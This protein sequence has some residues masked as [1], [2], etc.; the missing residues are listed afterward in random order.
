MAAKRQF[1][2]Q[3]TSELGRPFQQ[4]RSFGKLLMI[5]VVLS[6]ISAAGCLWWGWLEEN[7]AL[8]ALGL[9]AALSFL[10]AGVG[11]RMNFRRRDVYE[12]A[13]K[14]D[15][16]RRKISEGD[17]AAK[18]SLFVEEAESQNKW[19]AERSFVRFIN[20]Y[21]M[22][23]IIGGSL[24]LSFFGLK[25]YAAGTEALSRDPGF[26]YTAGAV[27]LVMAF[28]GLLGGK[29][30]AE[31]PEDDFPEAHG[32]KLIFR[33]QLYAGLLLAV[34]FFLAS[35]KY[36]CM[37]VA[38]KIVYMAVIVVSIELVLRAAA[39][40]FQPV[41]SVKKIASPVN[42]F[43]LNIFLSR[44]NPLAS[45]VHSIEQ[46]FGLNLGETWSM[47]FLMRS[48]LPVTLLVLLIFWLSSAFVVIKPYEAGL[49]E[50]WG[51]LQ[52]GVLQPG[53]H[54]KYPWPVDSILR[55]PVKKVQSINIGFGGEIIGEYLW[56]CEH[57]EEEEH[58]ILGDGK[59]M[60]AV[61]GHVLYKIDEGAALSELE[62]SLHKFYS[63]SR[64]PEEI[65][66]AFTNE[67]LTEV[68]M[69]ESIDSLFSRNHELYVQHMREHIEANLKKVDIGITIVDVVLVNY[70][71]PVSGMVE[72]KEIKVAEAYEDVVSAQIDRRRSLIEAEIDK[73]ERLSAAGAEAYKKRVLAESVKRS[74]QW[75]AEGKT[76]RFRAR[77]PG[78]RANPDLYEEWKKLQIL[79]KYLGDMEL[80]V[81]D[82]SLNLDR[83]E[84]WLEF[85][86]KFEKEE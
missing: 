65:L 42:S 71:P 85:R 59:D 68:T 39:S 54:I 11:W 76:A 14:K 56:S 69:T 4:A 70:H 35:V 73:V 67:A 83:E 30:F 66:R 38:A 36:D 33:G 53:L 46:E 74:K 17:K 9:Y 60:L 3:S 25:M 86:P 12:S 61:T 64:E 43:I 32:L 44:A 13:E 40:F 79:E 20:I 34:S 72:G 2:I 37:D 29:F 58:F 22:I 7:A 23:W 5:F 21:Q 75:T 57:V 28:L 78:Y 47:Q 81:I 84:F 82:S 45:I 24:L 77:E 52:K 49:Y 41:R 15:S 63:A 48:L 10:A 16:L 8:Q 18:S 80:Y 31:I 55:F 1:E 62:A 26:Y 50:H 19:S 27:A 51:V 6:L